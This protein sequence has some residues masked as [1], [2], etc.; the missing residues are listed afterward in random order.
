[1][2][3]LSPPSC[4]VSLES[5]FT[6]LL[7]NLWRYEWKEECTC[8]GAATVHSIMTVCTQQMMGQIKQLFDY[9]ISLKL[10]KRRLRAWSIRWTLPA[11]LCQYCN[12]F[13]KLC[14]S[15]SCLVFT[16][17]SCTV[18]SLMVLPQTRTYSLGTCLVEVT[19]TLKYFIGK[20]ILLFTN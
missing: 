7:H 8:T 1:M 13:E 2:L 18:Q 11:Y 4:N 15:H 20:I 5:V 17:Q 19:L 6:P 16:R 10:T 12:F 9:P 14:G 3:L